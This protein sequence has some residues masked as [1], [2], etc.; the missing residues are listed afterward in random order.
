ME[1]PHITVGKTSEKMGPLSSQ[2]CEFAMG[3]AL[4][5]Q[6]HHQQN[7]KHLGKDV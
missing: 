3:F 1:N 5:S 2:L 4:I 7:L 6:V